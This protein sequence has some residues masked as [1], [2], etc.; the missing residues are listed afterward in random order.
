MASPCQH[1]LLITVLPGC[2]HALYPEGDPRASVMLQG[3]EITNDKE[4]S[5]TE[6]LGLT[7]LRPNCDFAL[8]EA[9]DAL[10]L[11]REAPFK[12][13]LIARAVGWSAHVAEQNCEGNL[14]RPR[15]QYI[16]L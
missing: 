9:V 6:V 2:G 4:N 3:I 14:I 5:A 11:P 8:I 1:A 10:G 16:G 13:S 15:R 7:G 12:I